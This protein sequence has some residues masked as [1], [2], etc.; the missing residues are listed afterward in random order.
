MRAYR[1]NGTWRLKP[2]QLGLFLHSME[3][4]K[5]WL[6]VMNEEGEPNTTT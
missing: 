3:K 6:L 5:A 2:E 4:E 1:M